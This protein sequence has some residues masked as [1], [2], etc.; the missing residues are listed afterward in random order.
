MQLENRPQVDQKPQVQDCGVGSY[1]S[2]VMKL[3]DS[4]RAPNPRRVRIFLVE[5]GIDV[6]RVM[7][8]LA[9]FEHRSDEFTK[10]NPLRR[11][12]TLELDDGAVI[13]ESVAISRYF[14][15]LYPEPP[16]FG[17]TPLEKATIE[18]WNRRVELGFMTEVQM[19]FRHGHPGMATHEI[20]QVLEWA[21]ANKPKMMASLRLINDRLGEVPFIAGETYS[22]ADITLLCAVDFMKP[23]KIKVP[24]DHKHLWRWYEDV[25]ARPS[26]KA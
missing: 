8:D 24:E 18:M 20:P 17:R 15:E 5:K 1:R 26:A 25:N 7:V 13:T 21:E 19:V 11:T 16:L 12:P 14:E 10:L 3:Y 9:S 6:S 22:I 4:V 2:D 23:T